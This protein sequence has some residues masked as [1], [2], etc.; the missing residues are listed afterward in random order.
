MNVISTMNHSGFVSTLYYLR[1]NEKP[2]VLY[3][4]LLLKCVSN[5]SADVSVFA[6]NALVT[7]EVE[8]IFGGP[9]SIHAF[10]L[11]VGLGWDLDES[12]L[13]FCDCLVPAVDSVTVS[14]PNV[15]VSH[16]DATPPQCMFSVSQKIGK[17]GFLTHISPLNGH[18][19]IGRMCLVA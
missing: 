19:L 15:K 12:S 7:E 8:P 6:L 10:T 16:N 9:I 5:S 1:S 2:L 14:G 3:S 17:E 18:N 13:V 4:G 11:R